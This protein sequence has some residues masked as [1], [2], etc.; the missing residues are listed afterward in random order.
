MAQKMEFEVTGSAKGMKSTL[1]TKQHTVIIDEPENM[2]GEDTGPD[3]LANML[4]SLAGCENVIA[5]M[6]AKEIGFDLQGIDFRVTGELD[7]RGLMGDKDV[8]SYF[9]QVGIE[10]TVQTS[11]SEERIEELK[12]ITDERCPVFTTFVA[13]GIPIDATWKKA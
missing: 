13:A 2:G 3:P 10:A 11:E 7:P 1:T 5:N 6:V 9:Q 4:A 8:Q 12:K